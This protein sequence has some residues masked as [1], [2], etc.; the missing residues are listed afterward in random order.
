MTEVV[1]ETQS[2]TI[3]TREIIRAINEN[4]LW[5]DMLKLVDE[6]GKET[7]DAANKAVGDTLELFIVREVIS[8]AR[9][10]G[11]NGA[12]ALEDIRRALRDA[13]R[14]LDTAG[15][16]VDRLIDNLSEDT[17]KIDIAMINKRISETEML[18]ED[19]CAR[20]RTEARD[21]R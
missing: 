18:G 15:R 4:Y 12:E 21:L 19:I 5:G 16:I 9:P 1:K 11:A 17:M 14:E 13:A 20:L 10:D 3:S 6:N 2:K 7:D 8:L